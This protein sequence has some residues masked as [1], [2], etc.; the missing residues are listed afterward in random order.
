MLR[1][2]SFIFFSLS[3]TL[4]LQDGPIGAE[5]VSLTPLRSLAI[6]RGLWLYGLPFWIDAKLPWRSSEPQL[7]HRLMIAQDTGSAI[8]GAA[9]GDVFFGS[10]DEAGALAGAIRHPAAFT[11][12]LPRGFYMGRPS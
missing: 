11:V 3:D 5:G 2:K 8:I 10:G 7:F 4:S 6:D 12:L 1:N 9:R